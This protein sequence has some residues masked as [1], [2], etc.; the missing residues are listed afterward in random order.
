MC[1]RKKNIMGKAKITCTQWTEEEVDALKRLWI[2]DTPIDKIAEILTSR[3]Q[4]GI[5]HKAAQL[6]L[7][8]PKPTINKE[9][10]EK[11]LK[12]YEC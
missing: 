4:S 7:E 6:K 8:R 3:T 1:I 5:T 10:L 9:L 12:I 11:Y 2:A